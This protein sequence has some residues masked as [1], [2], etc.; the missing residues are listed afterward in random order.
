MVGR[1]LPVNGLCNAV[2]SARGLQGSRGSLVRCES[3]GERHDGGRLRY[4]VP[5]ARARCLGSTP[6]GGR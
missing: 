6:H 5:G 4:G 2:S 3:R 1:I